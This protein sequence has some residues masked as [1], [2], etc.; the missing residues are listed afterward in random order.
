MPATTLTARPRTE[1][2]KNAMRRL[3]REGLVPG[4][5]YGH[6]EAPQPLSLS[7]LELE[8]VL[9]SIVPESTIV[10]V[11]IE[12]GATM[13]ALIREV[14]YHPAR[15]QLLHVDLFHVHAGEKIH[16]ELAVRLHG[17]PVGVRDDGGV[18]QQVLHT[19]SAECL[20]RDL[21]EAIDVDVDGL[22]VGE[23]LHV[24]D[25]SA[26]NV[27]ILNDPELVVCVVSEPTVAALP[28]TPQ[29]EPGTMDLVE[30]E[31]VRGER[32]SAKDVPFEHG[33]AQPE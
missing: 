24:G 3:R 22:G 4:V 19:V 30:G 18:L 13:Q 6:G 10:D 27:R 14:Q 12:G 32:D 9:S 20:P 25:L 23:S 11:T 2:G 31:L 28:E 17:S 33:S 29:T 15:P 1:K 26:P 8:R 7:V 21:P 16:V 5:V